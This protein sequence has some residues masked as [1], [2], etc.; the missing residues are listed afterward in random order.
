M[1]T[2]LHLQSLVWIRNFAIWKAFNK[3]LFENTNFEK[4]FDAFLLSEEFIFLSSIRN[5]KPKFLRSVNESTVFYN[6][7]PR[8]R[9][10]YFKRRFI[11]PG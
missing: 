8:E 10:I 3:S 1:V 5:K 2:K 9:L 11:P 7:C 4:S 6:I